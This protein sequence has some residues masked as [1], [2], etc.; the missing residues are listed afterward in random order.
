[1]ESNFHADF[2]GNVRGGGTGW[3]YG[4]LAKEEV[5]M[6]SRSSQAPFFSVVKERKGK[7]IG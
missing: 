3:A 6:P 1:M 5:Q 4:E 7:E 2:D